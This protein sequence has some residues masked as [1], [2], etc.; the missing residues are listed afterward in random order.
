MQDDNDKNGLDEKRAG[1]LYAFGAFLLWGFLPIYWK[2]L[3]SIPPMEILAHRIIWSSVF[4]ALILGFKRKFRGSF[5]DIFGSMK[6][7]KTMLFLIGSTALISS[8]WL[9]YIWAVNSNYVLETS[10][11]YFI[12]PLLNIVLGMLFLGER[13]RKVQ[14]VA[15][16]FALIGVL[17]LTLSYG[18]FPWIAL[19][20]ALSFGLY[21]LLRKIVKVR[22]LEGAFIETFILSLPGLVYLFSLDQISLGQGTQGL[23]FSGGFLTILLLIGSG[24]VTSTP[25]VWFGNAAKKLPLSTLGLVQYLAPTCQFLLA[26]YLYNEPFTSHHL[27]TFLCIWAGLLIFSLEGL[28]CRTTTN[29]KNT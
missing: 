13:L 6:D 3:K 12:N 11:G 14:W 5:K 18:R 9:L 7:K 21:G 19:F 25:I 20:L 22:P 16:L 27:I 4:L 29:S 26:V 17:N 8:N 10:L 24:I 28:L 2:L 1:C 15:V 23:L